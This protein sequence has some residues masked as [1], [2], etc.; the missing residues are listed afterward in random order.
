MQEP[1]RINDLERIQDL[2]TEMLR[3]ISAKQDT[4]TKKLQ[5]IGHTLILQRTDILMLQ[6]KTADLQ[7][8]VEVIKA[9][10]STL[11]S[12]VSTIKG[13]I[14]ELR[15]DIEKR[16]DAIADV[17]KLILDRLPEKGK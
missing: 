9:D 10:V 6:N 1:N 17:Q 3:E 4:H 7:E 11:K 15:Q 8:D 12:D 5:E 13:S 16:F 14:I 2:H